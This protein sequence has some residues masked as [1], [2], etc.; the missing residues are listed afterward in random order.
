MLSRYSCQRPDL[1]SRYD[2]RMHHD[3]RPGWYPVECVVDG[4][5]NIIPTILDET[6]VWPR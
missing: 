1:D 3:K 2:E 4:W 6:M 5:F